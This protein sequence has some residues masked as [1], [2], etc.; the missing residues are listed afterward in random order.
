MS[1][2]EMEFDAVVDHFRE[3]NIT[4]VITQAYFDASSSLKLC[5]FDL[6]GV[7]TPVLTSSG[8]YFT[9]SLHGFVD[10]VQLPREQLAE[11]LQD[12][13]IR[14]LRILKTMRPGFRS[15]GTLNIVTAWRRQPVAALSSGSFLWGIN[16][17]PAL[18]PS[19]PFTAK[20]GNVRFQL[21][22]YH[23][24]YASTARVL[25]PQFDAAKNPLTRVDIR[26]GLHSHT[27]AQ[28]LIG[29]S[30]PTIEQNRLSTHLNVDVFMS[31]RNAFYTGAQKHL[32]RV[33]ARH[34]PTGEP[35]EEITNADEALDV[36]TTVFEHLTIGALLDKLAAGLFDGIPVHIIRNPVTFPL[37]ISMCLLIS[38]VPA[39][40]TVPGTQEHQ[41][42]PPDAAAV[43]ILKLYHACCAP[44]N[45]E[46]GTHAEAVILM[47]FES[48]MASLHSNKNGKSDPRVNARLA[49]A[50]ASIAQMRR[51]GMALARELRNVAPR[52]VEQTRVASHVRRI[53]ALLK[54]MLDVN[55]WLQTGI[56][57][58]ER[59]HKQNDEYETARL[60]GFNIDAYNAAQQSIEGYFAIGVFATQDLQWCC[61]AIP[62]R[63]CTVVRCGR[64]D[65]GFGALELIARSRML[66][67]CLC[68][69][70]YFCP[71]CSH[72]TAL[73]TRDRG[74]MHG[75]TTFS[76]SQDDVL[77]ARDQWRCSKCK[78]RRKAVAEAA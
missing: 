10:G 28:Y 44:L 7:P 67:G 4:G 62:F 41:N 38:A 30:S 49:S 68:C 8:E 18:L 43:E 6:A 78:K 45:A 20:D 33:N 46:M 26:R 51:A 73:E 12:R 21:A 3:R 27:M 56:F 36:A 74:L 54:L 75:Q 70:H 39:L 60:S 53:D 2:F 22:G 72:A 23:A 63:H 5:D 29:A 42:E 34:S 37:F 24:V 61:V 77:E 57:N 52:F 35:I 19:Y 66:G 1:E 25:T 65:R 32:N 48:T 9:Y 13:E 17:V 64:C 11:P 71:Q 59:V 31:K 15:R 50:A 69:G 47:S 76:I 14:V 55:G 58:G 16:V 40:V